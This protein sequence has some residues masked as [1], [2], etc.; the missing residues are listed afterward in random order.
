MWLLCE[1][2]FSNS[3]MKPAKT[4]DHLDRNR[5]YKKNKDLDY[6]KMLKEKLK[7]CH[8]YKTF[9]KASV[10]ADHEGG[11]K[12]SYDIFL[13]IARKGKWV[14]PFIIIRFF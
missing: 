12:T 2:A 8:N 1:E 10:K 6:F 7:N 13:N 3:D 9:F 14:N 4:K 5:S 11:L